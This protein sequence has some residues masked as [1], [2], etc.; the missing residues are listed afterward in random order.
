MNRVS[1]FALFA[2]IATSAIAMPAGMP[3]GMPGEPGMGRMDFMANLTDEQKSCLE[4]ATA[5]CP[6]PQMPNGGE[7]P[8]MPPHGEKPDMGQPPAAGEMPPAPQMPEMTEAQKAEMASAQ[9]CQKKAF[10]ICGIQ[11]PERPE[12]PNGAP[13]QGVVPRQ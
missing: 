8:K 3:N 4:T 11:M 7:R 2:M 6:K 13:E 1:M 9:E 10:E 5:D 12:R